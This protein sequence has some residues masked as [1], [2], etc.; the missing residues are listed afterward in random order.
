M[1]ANYFQHACLR[2]WNHN[3]TQK[4]ALL[5]ATIGLTGEAGEVADLVKKTVYHGHPQD[6]TKL[7]KEVGDVLYYV[8]VLSHIAG[9]DLAQVMQANIDKLKARY[10]NGF[11][12][13]DS[14]GRRE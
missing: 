8:A 6:L 4:D 12:V 1:Q 3:L 7:S 9:F 10:P 2:T 13:A 11:N 14:V 5:N